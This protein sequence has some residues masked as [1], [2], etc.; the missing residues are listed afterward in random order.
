MDLR[1]ADLC[2]FGVVSGFQNIWVLFFESIFLKCPEC[3]IGYN[4]WSSFDHECAALSWARL[5]VISFIQL[6][7]ME[8]DISN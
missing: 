7:F 3:G 6:I 8:T 4:N 5:G 1:D 2:F